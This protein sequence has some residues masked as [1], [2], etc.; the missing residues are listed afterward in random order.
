ML[1]GGV[2][3][4]EDVMLWGPTALQDA[5]LPDLALFR[6][7][8]EGDGDDDASDLEGCDG[9]AARGDE[10]ALQQAA[11]F[12]RFFAD[13][14]G[15]DD[16]ACEDEDIEGPMTMENCEEVLDEYLVGK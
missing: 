15:D 7:T 5:N 2:V 4:P 9:A 13:E 14:Y 12:E 1:P 8:I 10:D 16:G 3:E 11:Q 6:R